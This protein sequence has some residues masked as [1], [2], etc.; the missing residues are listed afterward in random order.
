MA[1]EL[2]IIITLNP[3]IDM[4][5]ALLEDKMNEVLEIVENRASDIALGP[6]VAIDFDE[7]SI[8]LAFTVQA[9]A[10]SG[11]HAVVA[12]VME[13]VEQH[14]DRSCFTSG[15]WGIADDSHVYALAG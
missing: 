10:P 15:S 1:T 2:D 3:R 7:K 5:D 11:A 4:N 14:T 8:E 13:I 6:A 9:D 12:K